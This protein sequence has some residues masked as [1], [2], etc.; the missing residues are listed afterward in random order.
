MKYISIIVLCFMLI[1]ISPLSTIAIDPDKAH[2]HTID[3][4]RDVDRLMILQ[5][6][7]NHSSDPVNKYLY[8][9]AMIDYMEGMIQKAE[10]MSDTYYVPAILIMTNEL[11]GADNI[12]RY[13]PVQPEK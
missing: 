11:P 12:P 3:F 8:T 6:K 9:M 13:P 4:K 5:A 1:L 2:P 7:F 10:N